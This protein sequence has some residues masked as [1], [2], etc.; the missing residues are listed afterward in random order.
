MQFFVYYFYLLRVK[1]VFK[2]F[3]ILIRENCYHLSVNNNFITKSYL[4]IF[5]RHAQKIHIE[6]IKGV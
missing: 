5:P 2:P 6:I 3:K 4:P 1:K